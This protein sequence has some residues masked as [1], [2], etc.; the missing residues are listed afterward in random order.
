MRDARQVE[1]R[2][3]GDKGILQLFSK[4]ARNSSKVVVFICTSVNV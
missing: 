3:T 4:H 2:K 1:E